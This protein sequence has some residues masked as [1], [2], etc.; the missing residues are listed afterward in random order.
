MTYV[1]LDIREWRCDSAIVDEQ[2]RTLGEAEAGLVWMAQ[3]VSE[4]YSR[5]GSSDVFPGEHNWKSREGGRGK[6]LFASLRSYLSIA[7]SER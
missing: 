6:G 3:L 2:S 4:D 1:G 7:E 5:H